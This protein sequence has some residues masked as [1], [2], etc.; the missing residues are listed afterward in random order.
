ME[1]QI[2]SI[3]EEAGKIEVSLT[4]K[5]ALYFADK[6]KKEKEN[7]IMWKFVNEFQMFNGGSQGECFR[8][9]NEFRVASGY[10]EWKSQRSVARIWEQES[11]FYE[12]KNV[13]GPKSAVA[14]FPDGKTINTSTREEMFNVMKEQY[15]ISRGT[16]ARLIK[17]GQAYK[18]RYAK[19]KQLNGLIIKYVDEKSSDS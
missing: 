12:H 15:N 1:L 18:S 7:Y 5:E 13:L 14:I 3:D 2:F 17:S 19:H 16:I 6:P 4:K 10:P 11:P 9:I 8:Q